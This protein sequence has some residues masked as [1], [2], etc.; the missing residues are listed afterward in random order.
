MGI[1][2]RQYLRKKRYEVRPLRRLW[3]N[4]GWRWSGLAKESSMANNKGSGGKSVPPPGAANG[5]RGQGNA[6]GRPSTTG[7][8]SGGN[9]SNA[10]PSKGK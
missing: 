8:P 4:L 5:N 7:Q 6:G 1:K 9:R 3:R 10:N 2:C